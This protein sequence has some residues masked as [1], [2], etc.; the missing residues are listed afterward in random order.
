MPTITRLWGC[1][2][3]IHEEAQQQ[4]ATAIQLLPNRELD[5]RGHAIEG[6]A[7]EVVE[8]TPREPGDG[9]WQVKVTGAGWQSGLDDGPWQ[10]IEAKEI[11]DHFEWLDRPD[12]S[13]RTQESRGVTPRLSISTIYRRMPR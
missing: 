9:R 4:V 6:A 7:Q 13:E 11:N 8:T 5:R 12:A 1:S 2:A 10:P 3:R